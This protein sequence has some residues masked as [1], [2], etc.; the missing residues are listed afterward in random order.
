MAVSRNLVSGNTTMLL[1]QMLSQKD[2]YGY[3]MIETLSERS[4]NV[5]ELKVGTLYP[6]LHGLCLLYTSTVDEI[7]THPDETV[8]DKVVQAENPALVSNVVYKICY[9]SEHF[10]SIAFQDNYA[11]GDADSYGG[12]LRTL[13][14]GLDDGKV[15]EI[16]D[17]VTLDD[18]FMNQWLD[19]MR[20]EAEND[21]LLKELDLQE[22]KEILQGEI[23]EDTYKENFFVYEEGIEIGFDFNYS[24]ND[25]HDLGYMWVTAPFDWDEIEPY[26]TDHKFWDM[27]QK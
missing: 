25:E 15:Y 8:K 19:V 6:L 5:F 21:A 27:L 1:L 13:N 9:Q 10:I 7:Y 12:D 22:M 17:V 20:S 18:K 3:E 24:E 11:K 14:I 16:K 4:R 2:M 26:K 23:K